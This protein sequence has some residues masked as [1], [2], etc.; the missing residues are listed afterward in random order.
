M[1][2]EAQASVVHE[3]IFQV[4]AKNLNKIHFSCLINKK[5]LLFVGLLLDFKINNL[6]A[7]GESEMLIK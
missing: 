7:E 5:S 2:S 4:L 1:K 3:Q 6:R